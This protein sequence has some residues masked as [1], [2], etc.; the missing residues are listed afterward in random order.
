MSERITNSFNGGMNRDVDKKLRKNDTYSRSVNGRLVFNEEGTYSWENAV[1]NIT[2]ISNLPINSTVIGNAQFTNLLVVFLII[3]TSSGDEYQIG[4]IKIDID[5]FG[6]Y[7]PLIESNGTP[8]APL[9]NFSTKYPLQCSPFHESN[10]LLRVY[11]TDD[12]NEPRA[13]TFKVDDGAPSGYSIVTSSVKQMGITVN[14]NMSPLIVRSQALDNGKLLSGMYQYT[15]RLTNEDGYE[16][17]WFPI[18]RHIGVFGG[19][20]DSGYDCN[21]DYLNTSTSKSNTLVISNIDDSY[22]T[23]EVAYVFSITPNAPLEAAIFYSDEISNIPT[24]ELEVTHYSNEGQAIIL[25]SIVDKVQFIKKAKTIA[26]KDNRLWL[27]NIESTKLIDIPDEVFANLDIKPNIKAILDDHSDGGT[28]KDLGGDAFWDGAEKSVRKSGVLNQQVKTIKHTTSTTP[29]VSQYTFRNAHWTD[30]TDPII[31]H[32]HTGYFRGETYRFG[33]TFFDKKGNDIFT[34]H[35]ADI[36]V[37]RQKTSSTTAPSD[38]S[39]LSWTRIKSDGSLQNGSNAYDCQHFS[40]TCGMLSS[41]INKNAGYSGAVTTGGDGENDNYKYTDFQRIETL[42]SHPDVNVVAK[43]FNTG[44]GLNLDTKSCLHSWIKILG[45]KFSG[46]NLGVEIEGT[47]LYDLVG[48]F[49]IVRVAKQDKDRRIV[50]QGLWFQSITDNDSITRANP[51]PSNWTNS[52]DVT[53]HINAECERYYNGKGDKGTRAL[54]KKFVGE[55]FSPDIAFEATTP[56]K[57]ENEKLMTV[58]SVWT[59]SLNQSK[60]SAG[61]AGCWWGSY[62][63][64]GT[65]FASDGGNGVIDKIVND[66]TGVLPSYDSQHSVKGIPFGGSR[67][68][69]NTYNGGRR[70][71]HYLHKLYNSRS[72]RD[73]DNHQFYVSAGK[74]LGWQGNFTVFGITNGSSLP[75]GEITMPSGQVFSPATFISY[76]SAYPLQ[77]T[78]DG[79]GG[80]VTITNW[81]DDDFNGKN[82][83][84]WLKSSLNTKSIILQ[85]QPEVQL[86]FYGGNGGFAYN[87]TPVC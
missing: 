84:K 11:F 2:S 64:A 34:V 33:C 19:Q 80:A 49:K 46:I 68:D 70:H 16:T 37:P 44:Y 72:H 22:K 78:G 87:G 79:S 76:N 27:G 6:E 51:H 31:E 71:H 65:P 85:V 58:G 50:R 47:P 35:L 81:I 74:D 25:E 40:S 26:V 21:F 8:D 30:Y 69:N 15:Y 4:I 17:P 75:S 67:N 32:A 86:G 23:I 61:I 73:F 55:F 82:E 10:T 24:L 83:K 66:Y 5:G 7:Y 18:T 60:S 63:G 42:D 12:Y 36:S 3:T 14:W 59:T 54:Y 29:A 20:D 56:I 9:L 52:G 13:F 38:T 28:A 41:M 57:Y 77:T 48:G 62:I 43:R 39:V 53:G 45:F 1:G